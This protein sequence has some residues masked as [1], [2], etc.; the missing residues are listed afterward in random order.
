MANKIVENLCKTQCKSPCK[1]REN[2]CVK[3]HF[4]HFHVDFSTFSQTFSH[5]FTDFPTAFSPLILLKLFHYST[6]PT[7]TTTNNI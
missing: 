7:T 4:A 5:F 2:L 1:S 6:T 3:P